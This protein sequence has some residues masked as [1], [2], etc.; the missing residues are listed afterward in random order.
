MARKKNAGGKKKLPPGVRERNGRYTFRYSV[1]VVKGGKQTRK[2]KE[3]E[4]F[5]TVQEAY[6]AGILIKANKLQGKP[7]DPKNL[8]LGQ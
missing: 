4:S 5:A 6:D 2:Q 1:P 7:I 3:T 8:T